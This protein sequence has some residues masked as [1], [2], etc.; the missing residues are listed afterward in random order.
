MY[1]EINGTRWWTAR[2]N[3]LYQE[4]FAFVSALQSRQGYRTADNLKYARLYGNYDLGG[5]DLVNYSR[6][7]TS[8]NTVNR[9]TLNIIQSMIDTV[10][11]KINKIC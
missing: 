2:K 4:L 1:E 8:Y 3:D 9:V 7:E 5:L 6:V 10:V 11:S